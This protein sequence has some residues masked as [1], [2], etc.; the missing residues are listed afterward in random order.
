MPRPV[1]AIRTLAPGEIQGLQN[2]SSRGVTRCDIGF[3]QGESS[4]VS[5]KRL[6]SGCIWRVKQIESLDGC[7]I[8]H[9]R[10]NTVKEFWHKQ[11][12]GEVTVIGD[13]EGRDGGWEGIGGSILVTLSSRLL[14]MELDV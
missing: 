3:D 11:L 9:E 6:D 12:E 14:N 13:G 7:Y 1:D 5:E 8:W 4:G 2:V 10:N